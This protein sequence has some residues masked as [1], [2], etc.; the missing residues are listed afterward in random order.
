M[1]DLPTQL[2]SE[3][4]GRTKKY[5][6]AEQ[7]AQDALNPHEPLIEVQ[8][9]HLLLHHLLSDERRSIPSSSKGTS[10]LFALVAFSCR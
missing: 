3:P 1:S 8:L 2:R 6:N 7:R 5:S 4:D 9:V 10:V